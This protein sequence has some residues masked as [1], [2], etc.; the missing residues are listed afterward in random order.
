M[1]TAAQPLDR[2]RRQPRACD[3]GVAEQRRRGAEHGAGIVQRP[4][5]H[6]AVDAYLEVTLS[7]VLLVGSTLLLASFI[8]LQRT[9]PGFESKGTAAAFVGLPSVRYSTPAQQA[10]FFEAVVE[11]LRAEPGV[12]DAAAAIGIPMTGSNF[13]MP[14]G[15]AGRALP[16]FPQRPLA[17]SG[18]VTDRYFALMHSD[19]RG[20]R[21]RPARPRRL[22]GRLHHQRIVRARLFPGESPL[23][24]SCCA[25][26]MRRFAR[27][28]SASSAT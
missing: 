10:R 7:V 8:R 11:R 2:A 22:A 6:A 20:P 14:Y 19:G 28:S 12:T 13:R 5:R 1:F 16:P 26:A 24:R 4:R 18:I 17:E 23:G 3:S 27:R 9:P 25:G 15:V 21:V